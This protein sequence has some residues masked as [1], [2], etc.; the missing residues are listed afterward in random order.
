MKKPGL[1]AF[2]LV[3]V[4]SAQAFSEQAYQ[5]EPNGF[6][7]YKWGYE[8][9]KI[10]DRLKYAKTTYT[11]DDKSTATDWYVKEGDILKIG[12]ANVSSIEYGFWRGKLT[13]V[14][15]DYEGDDN[16]IAVKETA[17]GNY[18]NTEYVNKYY[19]LKDTGDPILRYVSR[20]EWGGLINHSLKGKPLAR[21][22]KIMLVYDTRS[23]AGF[24]SLKSA[25]ADMDRSK[26]MRGKS[27]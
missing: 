13:E 16:F 11:M 19:L 27:R 14:N 26:A 23:R 8:L 12:S 6:R 7:D 5:N 25:Q 20:Y 3:I 17:F 21:K 1:L 15:I 22:T 2:I 18:G 24:L 10:K 9:S 4:F